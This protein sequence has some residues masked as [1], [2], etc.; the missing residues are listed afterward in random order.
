MVA[1]RKD[2]AAPTELADFWDGC[3][4]NMSRLRRW[5][6]G[7]PS[8]QSRRWFVRHAFFAVL[9]SVYLW[10]AIPG[11]E[12]PPDCI[13]RGIL[14]NQAG[15]PCHKSLCYGRTAGKCVIFTPAGLSCGQIP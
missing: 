15:F 10:G 14:V 3:S 4:T 9:R 6:C 5:F 1:V 12:F 11:K 2:Y 8:G 7:R 13:S